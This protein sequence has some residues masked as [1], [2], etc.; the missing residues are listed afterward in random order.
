MPNYNLYDT[1]S[2]QTTFPLEND[3]FGSDSHFNLDH[4]M[5]SLY[6]GDDLYNHAV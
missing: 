6:S 4:E 5:A 3:F 2:S 1:Q